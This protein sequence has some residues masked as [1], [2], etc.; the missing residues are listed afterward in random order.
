MKRTRVNIYLIKVLHHCVREEKYEYL[1]AI[2]EAYEYLL[3]DRSK[4][5][6]WFLG[7]NGAN[8][9][10][11]DISGQR[12]NKEIIKY[13]Y[14]K[15]KDIDRSLLKLTDKRN[16]LFHYAAK[17]NECYP[18]VFINLYSYSFMRNSNHYTRVLIY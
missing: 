4:F 13:L 7:L 12:A 8:M 14:S 1:I 15:I 6:N 3:N 5:L 10:I 9:N 16:N 18:I 17:R 11:L 2:T